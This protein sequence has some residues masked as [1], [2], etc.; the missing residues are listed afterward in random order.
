MRKKVDNKRI[1]W[2]N[3]S[4]KYPFARLPETEDIMKNNQTG[5]NLE[6]QIETLLCEAKAGTPNFQRVTT[7]S[8]LSADTLAIIRENALQLLQSKEQERGEQSKL[9]ACYE[10]LSQEDRND[11]ESN[12]IQN[13]KKILERYCKEH[14]YKDIQHYEDDGYTGTNFNRPSFQ[15][16]LSDIK[17]GK[18]SRVIV[19][20]MSRLG[21]DY[22]QVGM[23][24]D[25]VFPEYDVHFIA[26]NDGVDSTR[27]ENEFTAIRNVFNE[28]FARDTSKKIKA[29]WQNKG[30][31][32][33]R[34]TVNTPY[35]YLKDPNDKKKWVIDEEAAAV[36]QKIFNL[37]VGG[38]GP[39][40]IAKWLQDNKVLT[41]A[42]YLMSK[43]LNTPARYKYDP[44]K[45]AARTISDILERLEYLGHTVNFRT[46]SKSYKDKKTML[47]DP[48][49]WV[50]F[51]NTHDPIIEESVF[52]I[53]QNLR[54]TRRRPTKMGDMGLFSG[55]VFCEDCGAKMYLCRTNQFTPEKEYYA[56]STYRHNREL[57]TPHTIRNIPLHEIVLQN[58]REAIAYVSNYEDEF[59]QEAADI[60]IR[61]RDKELAGNKKA[62]AQAEKRIIELDTIIKRLYEDNLT[63]KLTDERFIKLSRDYEAEQ[64]SLKS[65]IGI[66]Q[67]DITQ[68]EQKK[69][70][71]KHFITATKKYT[72]LQELDSTIIREFIN[73]IEISATDGKR[74]RR[75]K[76]AV[77]VR[78]I[79]IVYNFIGAFDFIAALENAEVEQKL[80]KTA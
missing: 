64:N 9:T 13:Q 74:G 49:K 22:L 53:V 28:M 34:L 48:D 38:K 6:N 77:E 16:M 2:Y 31:S 76:G 27:G 52:E 66:M 80:K 17:A 44:C 37:C 23:Y 36:V 30:K 25:M 39:A 60:S 11:G 41:P 14:G 5:L 50:I 45:W 3:N 54:K 19:K 55:L 43:G 7:S 4:M 58:L 29:T 61:E 59:I 21:R 75:K 51:E 78:K 15:K 68:R 72:D 1:L 73:R 12:S 57:C 8:A 47:N 79:S 62:L 63:G 20:D 65:T 10:R 40:Q 67:Q 26:V 33:E 32:G 56:C 18:V 71:V 24:T 42:A 35:G 69:A 70:N 46:Y